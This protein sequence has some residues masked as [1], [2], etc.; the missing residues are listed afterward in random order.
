[1]PQNPPKGVPRILPRLSYLDV[2]AATEWLTRAFGFREREGSR[3]V[4]PDGTI[5]LTEVELG[6]G[7]VMLGRAGAHDLDSPRSIGGATQM[8]V[9]YVDEVD[10]HF[11]RAKAGRATI[12]LEPEDMFWGDRRYEA[13]DLEGHRWGFYER[14]RDVSPEEM[15]RAIKVLHTDAPAE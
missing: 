11:E 7:V 2:A 1:M 12:V 10:R 9:V 4:G 15:E 6:D 3:L 13:L 8:L 5:G 14:V